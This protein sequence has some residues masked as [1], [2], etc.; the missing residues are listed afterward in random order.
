[1][2]VSV[3]PSSV[4]LNEKETAQFNATADG[5]NKLNF[6]YKW[7]KRGSN[8]PPTKVSSVFK[9]LFTIP[10]LRISDQGDYY[11]TVT[12]EWNRMVESYDVILKVKGKYAVSYCVYA[13]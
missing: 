2:T 10:D 6:V 5:I 9:A 1:M 13:C 12:N 11:C 4:E 8:F 7:K 3:A